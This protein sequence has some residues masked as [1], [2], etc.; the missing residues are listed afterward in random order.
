PSPCALSL[1][2]CPPRSRAAQGPSPAADQHLAATLRPPPLPPIPGVGALAVAGVL[3][4]RRGGDTKAL[5]DALP[6]A[7]QTGEPQRLMAVATA[8]AEA[9]WIAGRTPDLATEIDRAWPSAVAHPQPWDLGELCWWLHLAAD[10][11][12]PPA[13]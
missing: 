5:D 3:P 8:R 10:H 4:P 12:Q 1:A 6:I 13:P 11:R 2:A 7:V 9:A